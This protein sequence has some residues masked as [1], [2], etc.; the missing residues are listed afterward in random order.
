MRDT[1]ICKVEENS[2]GNEWRGSVGR[3]G[4]KVRKK[5][6]DADE[7]IGVEGIDGVHVSGNEKAVLGCNL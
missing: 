1:V 7:K 5:R 2:V 4:L 6:P 3:G